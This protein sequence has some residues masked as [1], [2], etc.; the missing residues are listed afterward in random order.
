MFFQ[1]IHG[2]A[3]KGMDGVNLRQS[4]M[5]CRSW[6]FGQGRYVLHS[7][8]LVNGH[9]SFEIRRLVRAHRGSK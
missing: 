5:L 8:D 9:L 2:A 6:Q 3:A 7:S 4:M 1:R